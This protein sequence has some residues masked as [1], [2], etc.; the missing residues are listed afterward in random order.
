[1]QTTVFEQVN[2]T[3]YHETLQNG[4]QVYLVPKQ[5]FS[6]T[7][8][9]FTTRYGSIDSHFRTRS[10]EEI[11]V[12][13]GIAHFLE[14]KMFE[15]KD[16]DVMHEFSKN[17]AS[18]NAFTSFNRTAYLFSCTDKLDDNLNLLLDYVQ[19]PY[20]TDASVEKE[21][22]IIGQEITMYDDNPDWKVYMNLLKAMYQKYP[23][24][25]EIAGTIETISHITKEYLYQCYETFYHPANMLLL[26]V[27]SF[28]PEAIMKLIREN[29]GA[30]EFSPAPQITRVFPEEPSAPA[31]AKVEAFLTVGLPKC[32]IGIKEKENG[33]TKEALLKRE[34]TTKLV[35]DI[36]FGTSSAV[37]ERLYDSELITESFDFDYSSEQDYAYTIIGGD[38]PDPERLVETIKAEIEQLKQNGIAQD[39]FER[40]KRKKIGNFMRS[41]NSVEFIANQFTSFKFNGNDLFSVV[42]T[43]ESITREDV[44]KR[45]KEHFLI[46]QMA[47]SIVRSAS[48]QE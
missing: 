3:V 15:K 43:L 26:V 30:K 33:L 14:H 39:D 34:L 20:F 40:A 37:Y 19:D 28:E 38:T 36:A 25:I 46:E 13:D 27:G 41:L 21:K 17:G 6:K 47:V 2:E 29:Q 32:M 42:P 16:R 18:C 5:G 11:N 7:Y 24:N 1:M 35:L 9:V 23:I 48:P 4:L 45:L 10:G 31:E 22:G 8:A 12:P 44:E